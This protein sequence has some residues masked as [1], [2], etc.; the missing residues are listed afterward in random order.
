MSQETS[1][2]QIDPS[3][4]RALPSRSENPEEAHTNGCDTRSARQ[5]ELDYQWAL[6]CELGFVSKLDQKSLLEVIKRVN[7][8]EVIS[9]ALV[10]RRETKNLAKKMSF[11]DEA[12]LISFME[13]NFHLKNVKKLTKLVQGGSKESK[14]SLSGCKRPR[15]SA[16]SAVQKDEMNSTQLAYSRRPHSPRGFCIYSDK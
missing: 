5:R 9:S 13:T 2:K 10:A 11:A 8:S 1:L 4:E 15:L 3:K 14:K 16:F 6:S 7:V 12:E